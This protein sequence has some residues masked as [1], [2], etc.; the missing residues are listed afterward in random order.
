MTHEED[1]Y[2]QTLNLLGTDV[3]PDWLQDA[4]DR[5]HRKADPDWICV[6]KPE[7]RAAEALPGGLQ[8]T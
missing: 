2:V 1:V 7:E 5:E 6:R 4:L 8:L 3:E